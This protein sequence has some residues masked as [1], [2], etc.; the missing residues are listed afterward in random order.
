MTTEATMTKDLAEITALS[1]F[2]LQLLAG[3]VLQIVTLYVE[4]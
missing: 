1:S 4:T 2:N 3:E